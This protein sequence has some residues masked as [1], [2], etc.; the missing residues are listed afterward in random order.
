R[1]DR[2]GVQLLRAA[3]VSH[4]DPRYRLRLPVDPARVV[5]E[6]PPDFDERNDLRGAGTQAGNDRMRSGGNGSASL[7]ADVRE[8]AVLQA[9]VAGDD[10]LRTGGAV[11]AGGGSAPHGV[12]KS[13]WVSGGQALYG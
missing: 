1:L 5:D 13:G 8:V 11:A 12:L 3:A 2:Q 6:A 7:P 9:A 10:T 4:T